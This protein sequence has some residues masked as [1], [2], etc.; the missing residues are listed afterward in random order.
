MRDEEATRRRNVKNWRCVDKMVWNS[1]Y[2]FFVCVIHAFIYGFAC[3]FLLY[4]MT[5]VSSKNG[6]SVK[7]LNCWNEYLMTEVG[8]TPH[9]T[10][11]NHSPKNHQTGP[12]SFFERFL[13]LLDVCGSGPNKKKAV[14]VSMLVLVLG[15]TGT[16]PGTKTGGW[17]CWVPCWV[18]CWLQCFHV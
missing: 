11:T 10:Y 17:P 7:C 13:R 2:F 18:P 3:C 6:F 12:S 5:F 4:S 15:S 14:L 1:L 9:W 16:T 8:P